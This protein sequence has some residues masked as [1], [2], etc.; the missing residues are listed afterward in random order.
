MPHSILGRGRNVK[1]TAL[2]C[3]NCPQALL[4]HGRCA[5]MLLGNEGDG[6]SLNEL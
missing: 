5:F 3:V 6:C 1:I 4:V 2:G